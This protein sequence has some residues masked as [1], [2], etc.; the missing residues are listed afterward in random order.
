PKV[1]MLDEPA[2]GMNPEETADLMDNLMWLKARH[3]CA[4][5]LI[6]HDLKFVMS[7]CDRLTVINM[8]AL[9]ASGTP[10]EVANNQGVKD[11]YLGHARYRR[12]DPPDA[13]CRA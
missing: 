12:A 5:I 13:R 3:P 1:L 8:G 11:A 6:E 2:E 7:A 9:L 10:S 4:I